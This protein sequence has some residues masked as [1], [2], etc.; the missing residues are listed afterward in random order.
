MNPDFVRKNN[1][2]VHTKSHEYVEM[3]LPMENN[4]VNG[5]E[6]L[7]LNLLHKWTNTKASLAGTKK[8]GTCYQEF[9][10]FTTKEIKQHLGV[11]VLNGLS[12]SPIVQQSFSPQTK[13]LIHGKYFLYQSLE[14]NAV[15]QHTHFKAFFSMCNPMIHS[16]SRKKFPNWKIRPM[17]LWMNFLFLTIWLMG[18]AFSV[19]EMTMGFQGRHKDKQ[20]ITYK[21]EGG[22]F[23]CDALC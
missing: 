8:G 3:V 12:P 9:K 22:G 6:I 10:D 7:S 17:L 15:R 21:N 23:Q 18:L 20:R 1:I 16:P 5:E 13:D 19:N 2:T 11:Y 4:I 14:E